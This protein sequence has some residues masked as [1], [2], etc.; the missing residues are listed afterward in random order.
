MSKKRTASK[1]PDFENK[2]KRSRPEDGVSAD[3]KGAEANLS[4]SA[5]VSD[6]RIWG[7]EATKLDVYVWDYLSRRGFNSA[8]KALMNE[9]GMT[10]PPEVPLRTPQGLLFEY[11]AIFWDVFAARSGRGGTEA[12]AYY[13]YQESRNMQRL[14]EATRKTE[15][16]EAQYQPPENG[17]RFPNI[18]V[19]GLNADP[20]SAGVAAYAAAVGPNGRAAIP[21]AWN[22]AALPQAQQQQLLITAAQRQNIPLHEIKNLTPASRMALI[23]SMNPNNPAN[24]QAVRPGMNSQLTEQQLQVRL[25]QQQQQ[26][27]HRAMQ[28]RQGMPGAAPMP[29]AMQ[30]RPPMGPQQMPGA[31][32]SPAPPTPGGGMDGR[33]SVGPG[34]E[35]NRLEHMGVPP[36]PGQGPQQQ[37]PQLNPHQQQLVM[38][39]Y[40]SVQAAMREEWMKAQN[41]P[42][43]STA[44]DFYANMQAY[45]AKAQGLQ[46]LL[47]AQ[48]NYQG[49]AGAAAPGNAMQPGMPGQPGPSPQAR[50]PAMVL[51]AWPT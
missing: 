22:P 27:L 12:A 46:N 13:E 17:S 33:R 38:N 21:G 35:G 47:R 24:A 31:G 41:A 19:S 2:D 51:L 18:V 14:A 29:N 34:A 26:A 15:A 9:A 45:H 50:P 23:N 40:Q 8:A 3:N 1:S 44:A 16:L 32:G 48:A 11:W 43:Q 5:S 6:G 25:Q 10:E 7:E 39:Q 20:N 28:Q 4:H 49:G 37:H 30:V 36:Q 42:N